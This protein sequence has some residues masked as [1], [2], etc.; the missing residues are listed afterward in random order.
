MKVRQLAYLLPAPSEY[1]L[2]VPDKE[3]IE[4]RTEMNLVNLRRVIYLTLMN[5]LNY[6][7]AVHKLLKVQVKEGEEVYLIICLLLRSLTQ[8]L[9]LNWSTWS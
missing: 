4:D 2:A 8:H 6:E 3:G 7:E 5:A 9:R 1:A